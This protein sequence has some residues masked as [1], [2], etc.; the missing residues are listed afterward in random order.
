MKRKVNKKANFWQKI[1]VITQAA[2][3]LKNVPRTGWALKGV[4]EVE[5]VADHSH[6]VALLGMLL[7]DKFGFDR[8]KIVEMALIHDLGECGIGDIKW[9]SGRTVLVP[10]YAKHR[11]EGKVMKKIFK[12]LDDGRKYFDLWREF[13]YQTTPEAKFVKQLDK[14]EMAIQALEYERKGYSAELFDEFW[15]NVDKYLSGADLEDVFQELKKTRTKLSVSKK[16]QKVK[17]AQG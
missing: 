15:E 9:E 1:I 14:L 11:D 13:T 7:S 12:D 8:G 16:N 5:S 3:L 10:P 2:G 17:K 4:E 6:R